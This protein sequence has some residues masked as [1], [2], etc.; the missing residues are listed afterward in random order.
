MWDGDV[1]LIVHVSN[2][3]T[4]LSYKVI[5]LSQLGLYQ[6]NNYYSLYVGDGASSKWHPVYMYMYIMHV[7]V[8]G[9]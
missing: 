3:T 6:Y 1:A 2:L 4:L 5:T 8:L 7:E 9:L